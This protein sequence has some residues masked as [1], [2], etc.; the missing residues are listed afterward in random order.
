MKSGAF[1][2]FFVAFLVVMGVFM[3]AAAYDSSNDGIPYKDEY[4][5]ITI[6]SDEECDYILITALDENSHKWKVTY[7]AGGIDDGYNRY[8]S[9]SIPI[10]IYEDYTYEVIFVIG[11]GDVMKYTIDP[12]A[13]TVVSEYITVSPLPI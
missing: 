8:F 1:A 3:V 12:V 10:D 13:K 2:A 7:Y 6:E 11:N 5:T 4:V 9:D